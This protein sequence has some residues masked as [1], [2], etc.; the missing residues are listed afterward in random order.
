MLA[1]A[2]HDWIGT[3]VLFHSPVILRESSGDRGAIRQVRT[4]GDLVLV[5]IRVLGLISMSLIHLELNFYAEWN[6]WFK[7]YSSAY[8]YQV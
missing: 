1:Q 4:Q 5:L 6:I 8:N 7:F 3:D 2:R